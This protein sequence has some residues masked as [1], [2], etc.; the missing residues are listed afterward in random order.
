MKIESSPRTPPPLPQPDPPSESD[1]Q[2]EQELAGDPETQ[3][4]AE[5]AVTPTLTAQGLVDLVEIANV[6]AVQ[7]VVRQSK[8]DPKLPAV[9]AATRFDANTR[10]TLEGLAPAALPYVQSWMQ[11]HA[12]V[13]LIVFGGVAAMSIASNMSTVRRMAPRSEV[14]REPASEPAP[15]GFPG[16]EGPPPGFPGSS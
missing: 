1:A 5:A 11:D 9:Q 10:A 13:G 4:R 14:P 8:V 15:A 6:F 7:L 12:L 2:V 16:A 3:A